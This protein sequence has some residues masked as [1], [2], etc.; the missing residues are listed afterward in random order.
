MFTFHLVFA[1]LYKIIRH[2]HR[3]G[4]GKTVSWEHLDAEGRIVLN[5]FPKDWKYYTLAHPVARFKNMSWPEIRREMYTCYRDFYSIWRILLRGIKILFCT[6]NI[7]RMLIVFITSI[8]FRLEIKQTR[9]S[10][11]EEQIRNAA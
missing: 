7:G 6:K 1:R 2:K 5:R 4:T 10:A 8:G 3:N 9:E 11:I